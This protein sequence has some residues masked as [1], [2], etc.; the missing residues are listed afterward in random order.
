MSDLKVCTLNVRGLNNNDKRRKLFN[1][2]R[3]KEL[4]VTFLQETFCT[5]DFV[6]Y[7]NSSWSG[8][9]YHGETDSSHSRGVAIVVNPKLNFKYE[10]QH[11]SQDGRRLIVNGSID[12]MDISLVC[13]YAPNEQK[14]RSEFFDKCIIWIQKHATYKNALMI[15]GD[16]NCCLHDQDRRSVRDKFEDK[17]RK[18]LAKMIREL[19]IFDCWYKVNNRSGFTFFDRRTGGA[20]RLDYLF[21]S[22]SIP[23]TIKSTCV[24]SSVVPDHES[25]I[26][27]FKI[28][29]QKRGHGYWKLNNSLL[30]DKDYTEGIKHVILNTVSECEDLKSRRLVWELVKIRVKE[31]SISF[32]VNKSRKQKC[33]ALQ[34]ENR[35]NF[36]I[37]KLNTLDREISNE[38]V[39]Q[40]IEKKCEFE[41]QLSE[42]LDKKTKGYIIRS[43]IKW[44]EEGEKSTRY[45]LKLEKGRQSSNVFRR[46]SSNN[47]VV[48]NNDGI[49]NEIVNFYTNL[50]RGD[51]I[52]TEK[53]DEYMSN[54]K[55]VLILSDNEKLLCDKDINK[56]EIKKAISCILNMRNN[57]SY[58]ETMH[59]VTRENVCIYQTGLSLDLYL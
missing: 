5:K 7:F 27:I 49:L 15:G 21:T 19:N 38:Y 3:E 16:L 59:L 35:I 9:I 36:L 32:S 43:R 20:S 34:L 12:D 26:A 56:M 17:S 45:F 51:N 33:I 23:F 44:I 55:N 18:Q 2:I 42:I 11:R 39:K 46:V 29:S 28:C 52:S 8:K 40:L 24:K 4:D 13:L 58:G 48:V 50:Y 25:V 31:F 10:S 30:E 47:N 53:V 22:N 6:P 41:R 57:R 14:H 1:W 37:N 54:V